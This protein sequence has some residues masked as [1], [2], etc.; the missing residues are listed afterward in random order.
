[1]LGLRFEI[2]SFYYLNNVL[3]ILITFLDLSFA[4]ERLK[5]FDLN[6]KEKVKFKTK[7]NIMILVAIITTVPNFLVSLT[8]KPIGIV[9]NGNSTETSFIIAN[10]DLVYNFIIDLSLGI[11]SFIRGPILYLV[12]L[13]INLIVFI[14]FKKRIKDSKQ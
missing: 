6:H 1:M 12:I 4:I 2:I 14:K 8:V 9:L 5:A 10:N 3:L 13:V 7:L 11:M